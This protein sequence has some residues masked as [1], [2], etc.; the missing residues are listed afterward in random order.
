MKLLLTGANGFIGRAL[1][2]QLANEGHQVFNA[3]RSRTAENNEIA[4]GDLKTFRGWDGLLCGIDV[5]V[6]LAGRAHILND[7]SEGRFEECRIMNANVTIDL[8]KSAV[9]AGAKRFIFVSTIGVN[10]KVTYDSPFT[11]DDKPQPHSPYAL[12][13]YEAE[14]ALRDISSS[15]DL[16]TVIIRPPLVY[17][18]NAPGNFGK[19]ISW[20]TSGIPLPFGSV[21]GNRRSLVGLDNL[22]DLIRTCV[23]HPNAA[24]RT[25][26]VS[27]DHDM[28]TAELL[29]R[30]SLCLGI[31]PRLFSVP[32]R[33]IQF[34]GN[35]LGRKDIVERLIENLQVDIHYTRETLG[36]TPPV[37]V[38]EGFA[39]IAK[40]QHI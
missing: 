28:S 39:K 5:I 24:N 19:M 22:I 21:T 35:N 7:R 13:K 15:T 38:E 25:F 11:S 14:V 40:F 29:R 16:E 31:R 23:E 17:G 6:H 30:L 4:V 8:A 37:S 18:P 9:R 1:S 33:M 36:W 2:V 20:L 26:L 12:S 3:V 27:D 32:P 10:G 34:I